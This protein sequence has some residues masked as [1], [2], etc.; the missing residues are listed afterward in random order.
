MNMFNLSSKFQKLKDREKWKIR[1]LF[2]ATNFKSLMY[3]CF[4]FCRI[5]GIFPY[6]IDDSTFKISKPCYILSCVITCVSCVY[7]LTILYDNFSNKVK[8]KSFPMSLERNCFYIFGG[9]I[10]VVTFILTES[11]MRLIQTIMKISLRLP[12]ESYQNLSR[13]IHAK[14][15]FGFFLIVVQAVIYYCRMQF[16]I[17][18]KIFILYIVLLVFQMDMLY[19]NCVCVLKACFKQI[20]DNLTNLRRLMTNRE[21]SF[22]RRTYYEHKNPLVLMQLNALKKQHL[23]LSGTVQKLKI[24][25][26]LQLLSTIVKIFIQITLNLYF[27]LVRIQVRSMSYKENQVYYKYFISTIAYCLI[28]IVLIVWACET[29]KNQAAEISIRV[30]DTFN[31][32]S[33]K[34]IKYEVD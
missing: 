27:Y 24:I 14:D 5:L 1:W 33:D 11:R 15:I 4:T 7:N 2:H 13:M 29:G 26:S 25:F 31:S 18:R 20:N 8:F 19:M 23:A 30:Q 22:L 16:G 9:F 28:K 10:A 6:K 32:A 34:Q 3:P 21:P 17:L 12:E